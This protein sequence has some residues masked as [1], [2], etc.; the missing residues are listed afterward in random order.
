MNLIFLCMI[1]AF[2]SFGACLQDSF[3]LSGL[4]TTKELK[5][6]ELVADEFQSHMAHTLPRGYDLVLKLDFLSP[7]LNAE[8]TKNENQ[9]V[10]Q[11]WGGM[12]GHENLDENAFKLLLCHEIGHVLG[13][14]PL[15]SKGGWSS[16]EGQSDYFTGLE[17]AHKLGLNDIEFQEAALKLASIYAEVAREPKPK[18][19][20]CDESVVTRINYGYPKVQCR[21]DTMISGW[22]NTERPRCWFIEQ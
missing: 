10:I 5:I 8:V 22:R 12:L 6:M 11:V 18:L 9:I 19:D 2:K 7:R 16:T 15:K 20:S 1:I 3:S 14:A 17:C 21:L 4:K 13:G